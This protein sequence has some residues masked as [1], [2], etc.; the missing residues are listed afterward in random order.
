MIRATLIG[1]ALFAAPAFAE[2]WEVHREKDWS[3]EVYENDGDMGC[4]AG[5][6]IPGGVS[7]YLSFDQHGLDANLTDRNAS[8]PKGTQGDVR[9]WVDRLTE[10]TVTVKAVDSL[11][12]WDIP[13][14]DRAGTFLREL[15]KGARLYVSLNETGGY[16][17]WFSLSGSRAA[18]QAFGDCIETVE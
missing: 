14:D 10:W 6:V 1:A 18:L 2:S 7:F 17:Y 5:V 16:T 11:M 8:Y 12:Y 13:K 9:F 4:R 3:V 15:V